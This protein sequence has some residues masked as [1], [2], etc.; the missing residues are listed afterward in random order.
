MTLLELLLALPILAPI[1][2][3]PGYWASSHGHV[4]SMK[5]NRPGGS[6]RM[7]WLTEDPHPRKGHLRV[8]VRDANRKRCKIGVHR[9][10]CLAFHGVPP[11]GAETLDALHGNGDNHDN[12]PANLRWG[13]NQE[14]IEDR[15]EHKAMRESWEGGWRY[16][17]WVGIDRDYVVDEEFGF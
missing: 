8:L 10:I 2:G 6:P 4:F 12:R 7:Q 16:E 1:P 13:T 14:N 3:F 15:E 5:L 9:L 11:E 17:H